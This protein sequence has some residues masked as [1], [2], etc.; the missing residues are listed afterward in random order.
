MKLKELRSM[1]RYVEEFL[2]C[3]YYGNSTGKTE[4]IIVSASDVEKYDNYLVHCIHAVDYERAVIS[5]RTPNYE[6]LL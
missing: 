3:F 5:L 6:F 1:L 4:E 2:L